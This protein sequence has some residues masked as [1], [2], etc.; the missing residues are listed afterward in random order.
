[1]RPW[2]FALAA[3]TAACG[4]APPHLLHL[5]STE[6]E[7]DKGASIGRAWQRV[8]GTPIA[9]PPGA[10]V[11]GVDGKG[12]GLRGLALADQ[13]GWTFTHAIDSRPTIAANVVVASGGGEVFALDASSGQPVWR[14]P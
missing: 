13:H 4:A 7:D 12:Q 14:R 1:M 5:F 2:I 6:W 8:A 3:T 11:V 10:L 9:S